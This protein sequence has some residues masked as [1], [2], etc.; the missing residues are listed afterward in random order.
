MIAHRTWAM[1]SNGQCLWVLWFMSMLQRV[2]QARLPCSLAARSVFVSWVIRNRHQLHIADS[3]T[4][5]V[6]H[7]GPV[8]F[9]RRARLCSLSAFSACHGSLG[10]WWRGDRAWFSWSTTKTK[11]TLTEKTAKRWRAEEEVRTLRSGASGRLAVDLPGFP[12][13]VCSSP[14]PSGYQ[15]SI[16]WQQLGKMSVRRHF[17]VG[18]SL[19]A[20]YS[21]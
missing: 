1:H 18:F 19:S 9:R 2:C 10:C 17:W 8:V 21:W 13:P 12:V 20:L 14:S 7:C 6:A 16:K 3:E 15:A 5:T 4:T 11:W